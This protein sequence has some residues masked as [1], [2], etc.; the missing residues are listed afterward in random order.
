MRG[1]LLLTIGLCVATPMAAAANTELA[2]A[3]A[4]SYAEMDV[5]DT[6]A[7]AC[8]GLFVDERAVDAEEERIGRAVAA[9]YGE[10]KVEVVVVSP[11]LEKMTKAAQEEIVAQFSDKDQLCAAAATGGVRFV[12]PQPPAPDADEVED[13][14]GPG[15]EPAPGPLG[16]F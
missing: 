3:L 8:P 2:A 13:A 12:T 11:T 10:D 4:R 5:A 14:V 15:E 6:V 7:E 9:A 1:T 16:S